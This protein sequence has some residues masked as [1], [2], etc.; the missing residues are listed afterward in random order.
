MIT[1]GSDFQYSN[2]IKWF[3]N[4]DILIK[5]VN[6]EVHLSSHRFFEEDFLHSV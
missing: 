1:M 2:A 4:L 3:K 5:Y 6:A